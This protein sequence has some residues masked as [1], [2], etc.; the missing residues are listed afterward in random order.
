[1]PSCAGVLDWESDQAKSP[2]GERSASRLIS[3]WG[4][5]GELT[6]GHPH[7]HY[8]DPTTLPKGQSPLFGGQPMGYTGGPCG[9]PLGHRAQALCDC[10]HWATGSAVP[11][12]RRGPGRVSYGAGKFQPPGCP[13]KPGAERLLWAGDAREQAYV[14]RLRSPGCPR[15]L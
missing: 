15:L 2:G 8:Q 6:A 14:P 11:G 5:G 7:P 3:G 13:S 9:P 10:S 1:M 12:F 4:G